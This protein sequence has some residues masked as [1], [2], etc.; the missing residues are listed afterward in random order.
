METELE[1]EKLISEALQIDFRDH[2][3]I[4]KWWY[5]TYVALTPFPDEKCRFKGVFASEFVTP[6]EQIERGLE[7][8]NEV[9]DRLKVPRP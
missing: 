1:L 5:S 7:I 8:L 2:W 3:A 9:A 6:E 4:V